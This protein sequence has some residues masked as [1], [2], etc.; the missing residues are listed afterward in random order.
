VRWWGVES[1]GERV[2]DRD[3]VVELFLQLRHGGGRV[4]G[5]FGFV[6]QPAGGELDRKPTA[7]GAAGGC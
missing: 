6:A 1:L 7:R 3:Q 2:D 4:V 5:R